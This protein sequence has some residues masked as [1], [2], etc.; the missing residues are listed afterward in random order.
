MKFTYF[1]NISKKNIFL[2]KFCQT[3]FLVI[4]LIFVDFLSI[5]KVVDLFFIIK[6][7]TISKYAF[8]ICIFKIHIHY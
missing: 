6:N 7:K 4:R 2:S 1:L 5:F 8:D 3:A